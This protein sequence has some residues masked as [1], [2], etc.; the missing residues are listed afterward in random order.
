MAILDRREQHRDMGLSMGM[1]SRSDQAPEVRFGDPGRVT[2]QVGGLAGSAAEDGPRHLDLKIARDG[3]W[4]YRGSLI[5]RPALVQLF[6][7]VL[8]RAPDGRYWL[9][10]PVERGLVEVED[11]PFIAVEFEV[12]GAGRAQRLRLRSN[13]DDWVTLGAGHPLCLR[14]PAGLAPVAGPVPYV[15]MRPGLEARLARPVFYDLVELAMTAGDGADHA[16][17]GDERL[18]VWSDGCFIGLDEAG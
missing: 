4:F 15:E 13:V 17:G 5:A 1:D 9:V 16:G 10:T 7:S 2:G 14:R 11:V 8:Q 6:S 3:R 12:S 18:G